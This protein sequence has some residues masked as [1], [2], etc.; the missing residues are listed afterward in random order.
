MKKSNLFLPILLFVLSLTISC[1]SEQSIDVNQ[2]RIFTVFKLFYNANEDVT[3]AQAVF[4][5][6]NTTGTLL[7]LTE[8]SQVTFN[9]EFLTFNTTFKYYEKKLTGL[10]DSGTFVWKDTD[11][12]SFTN[13]VSID[14]IA[15]PEIDTVSRDAAF[16]IS[17]IGLPLIEREYIHVW[18]N[19]QYEDDASSVIESG[20]G[21]T[22]III[23]K[24][25]LEIIA[26]GDGQLFM[27]R[28]VFFDLQ[29]GTDAGGRTEAKYRAEDITIYFK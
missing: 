7:E 13:S 29:D 15:F 19:G 28:E 24:E 18:L 22:T 27:D 23:P 8:P 16:E 3:Y 11:E 12:K 14:S 4:R 17:W 2:D 21:K 10:V 26:A 25:K 9:D 6:G 1:E 20:V 5:F